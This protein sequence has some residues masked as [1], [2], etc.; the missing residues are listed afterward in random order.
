MPGTIETAR[1]GPDGRTVYYSERIAGGRPELF[2]LAPGATEPRPLGI[3]DALLLGVSGNND[4]AFIRE[5]SLTTS[6]RYRG[7]LAQTP[8]GGAGGQRDLQEDISEAAWDGAGLAT[9][10]IDSE[11]QGRLEF[12]TGTVLYQGPSTARYFSNL[13]LSPDGARLAAVDADAVA[14]AEIVTYDR[15]GHRKELVSKLG[16]AI[17][18]TLT[19]LA[20]GPG[21]E[22]WCSELQGDQTALWAVTAGGRRRPLWRSAGAYQLQ[23]VSADGRALMAL[24]QS[25]WSVLAQRAGEAQPRDL[26]ILG[27][28][29]AEGLSADG[30]HALLLESTSVDGG[31]SRDTTYL[32]PLDGGP[33]ARLGLGDAQTLSA[34]GRWVNLGMAPLPARD[35]DP[36]WL[37]ALRSAGLAAKDVDDVDKRN[38]YALFVPTGLGRPFALAMPEG[39]TLAGYNHLLPDGQ[40][41]VVLTASQGKGHWMLLDRRGAAPRTLTRDGLGNAWMGLVPLS[42]DATRLIVAGNRKEWFVQPLAGGDAQ[43]IR[44]MLPLE[45]VMGWS[46]D[47]KSVFVRPELSVLPVVITRLDLAT[48]ARTRIASFTPPDPAGHLQARGVFVTPDA[49]AFLLTYQKKLSELYLVEGLR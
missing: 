42:P 45:R 41:V 17:G 25:R 2:V 40:R 4:L 43:P 18:D 34:D 9:L 20:W 35:L 19:G 38:N 24:H 1:F 12:P 48:G 5:P 39:T 13:R 31:T 46:A 47:G 44:G 16:D 37:A 30:R 32:R 8:G 6:G 3:K 36:A 11:F 7:T 21:G 49:R 23:D 10:S 33:P 14:R 26:S 28:T 29:Q 15:A 27:N 22:L